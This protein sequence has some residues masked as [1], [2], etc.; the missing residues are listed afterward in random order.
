MSGK[1]YSF[2]LIYLLVMAIMGAGI[3]ITY[4]VM[5]ETTAWPVPALLDLQDM[6]NQ[7]QIGLM[8]QHYSINKDAAEI[9]QEAVRIIRQALSW[10]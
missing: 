7:W 2:A 4:Q 10:E 3:Y 1:S 9:L 8:G 6:G 5:I